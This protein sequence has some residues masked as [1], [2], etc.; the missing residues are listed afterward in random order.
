MPISIRFDDH[1]QARLRAL[2]DAEGV[3]MSELVRRAV[4]RYVEEPRGNLRVQLAD[5]IG[6]TKSGGGR[7]RRSGEAFKRIIGRRK[8]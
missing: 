6:A 8:K 5:V 2:A 7:A 4:A 3:S 1:L